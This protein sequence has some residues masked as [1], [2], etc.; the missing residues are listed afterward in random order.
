VAI[1]KVEPNGFHDQSSTKHPVQQLTHLKAALISIKKATQF[2]NSVQILQRLA[3]HAGS[4]PAVAHG[5]VQG[6]I[7]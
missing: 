6:E 3:I 1:V 4:H 5:T 2:T 7:S